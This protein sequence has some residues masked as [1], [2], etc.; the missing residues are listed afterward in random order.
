MK[1]VKGNIIIASG[2]SEKDHPFLQLL[3]S[4]PLYIILH[5]HLYLQTCGQLLSISGMLM[6]LRRVMCTAMGSLPKKSSCAERP[7]TP[8]T[9]GAT[10]V[11]PLVSPLLQPSGMVVVVT[12][13]FSMFSERH[14]L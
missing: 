6:Y 12:G 1:R 7:S 14:C 8:N 10:E 4:F 13:P 2:W 9:A 5:C 11:I 3:L